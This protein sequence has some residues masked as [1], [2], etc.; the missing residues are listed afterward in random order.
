MDSIPLEQQ[1]EDKS[2]I[3]VL[4]EVVGFDSNRH[5]HQM[6]TALYGHQFE[7]HGELPKD[8]TV[9]VLVDVRVYRSEAK[10]LVKSESASKC[11]P[12]THISMNHLADVV[13]LCAGM[14]CLGFGLQAAGFR[15]VAKV[16]WNQNMLR[17]AS[18]IDSTPT[19]C[20][21]ICQPNAIGSLCATSPNAGCLAAGIA[22]QPYSRL[23]DQQAQRDSRA[24]TL[25][26]VLR[27]AFL[28][29]YAI[30]VIECVPEAM[31]CKWVQ[32]T[33]KHYCQLT[34]FS[35][36]QDLLHLHHVWPTRRSRWWCVLS[37]PC[38]GKIP[39]GPL[40][41][42]DPIPMVS[43]L[44]D[45]FLQCTEEDLR[46][47][48]LDLY[49]L[50]KFAHFGV[51]TNMIP[52]K[53]QMK[54]SL[55]SCGNQ[56]DAC[57]C[58][59]RKY[60]FSEARLSQG[61]LHGLL[62]PL[63]GHSQCGINIYQNMRHVHPD[64]LA[65][66][67]GMFPGLSWNE[68][69]RLTL[70]ALGQLASPLQSCWVGAHIMLHLQGRFGE[71][72]GVTPRECLFGLMRDLLMKR[73][74]VFGIQHGPDAKAFAKMV[75]NRVFHFSLEPENPP[76]QTTS[77][78]G[79]IGEESLMS[80]LGHIK[81]ETKVLTLSETS[82][83]FPAVPAECF[84]AS[85]H[86]HDSVKTTSND[87][88]GFPFSVASVPL[89]D[90]QSET[91]LNTAG[92]H[93]FDL[94][95][96]VCP[97]E[98]LSG[99]QDFA[100]VM[101]PDSV[102]TARSLPHDPCL[103]SPCSEPD[104]PCLDK[105]FHIATQ[106]A[107]VPTCP[108][109]TE[110]S[111]E[112]LLDE[113]L[114]SHFL[115]VDKTVENPQAISPAGH[116]AP[117]MSATPGHQNAVLE[118]GTEK[119]ND[120]AIPDSAAL[121]IP[122]GIATD[123]LSCIPKELTPP[124][125]PLA[126]LT[127]PGMTATPGNQNAGSFADGNQAGDTLPLKLDDSGLAMPPGL[128]TMCCTDDAA[129]KLA[130]LD[131]GIS[132]LPACPDLAANIESMAHTNAGQPAPGMAATPGQ[133]DA[134]RAC[135][136]PE[137]P[138]E[139]PQPRV[140]MPPA[141]GGVVGFETGY[142]RTLAGASTG[143]IEHCAKTMQS[144][145]KIAKTSVED[146]PSLAEAHVEVAD[147][148]E[149]A[150]STSIQVWV[151]TH[152]TDSPVLVTCH[153]G[154]TAGMITQAEAN[155]GNMH[156]PI[157]PR[158]WVG[159]HVPLHE[160]LR[161]KQ[162]VI[163]HAKIPKDLKCPIAGGCQTPQIPFPCHRL[164]ALWKQ[165][166]WVA[167]DEME[168]YLASA[169]NV[170]Q[171]N[172]LPPQTFLNDTAVRMEAAAWL[173]QPIDW[174]TGD[175]PWITAAIVAGHWVP[176]IFQKSDG[177]ISLTTT[178][179][180]SPFIEAAQQVTTHLGLTLKAAQKMLPQAFH[181]DCGFQSFAWIMAIL[182]G[183]DVEPFDPVRAEKWRY[184]FAEH[185]LSVKRHD[186]VIDRLEL[187]GTKS[188]VALQRQLMD[189]L[190]NHG[191]WTERLTDKSNQLMEGV[192][193]HILKNVFL[194]KR[195]WADLKQ[196]ANNAQ[197]MIKLVQPDELNAQIAA[198][199]NQR[200]TYGQKSGQYTKKQS[201]TSDMPN[202]RAADLQVPHG[203]FK[204]Q[205]GQVLGPLSINDVGSSCQGVVLVDQS[206][207]EP[208][209]RLQTPVTPHG[210]A[211]IVLAT[212]SNALSHTQDPIRFPALCLATQ[213]PLIVSGYLYQLGTQ[214]TL[215][216][217]PTVKLAVEEHDTR[218]IR[219]LVF[220]DQAD[221]L[222]QEIQKQPVKVIFNQEPLLASRGNGDQPIVIDVWDRQWLSKRFEK[223]K[224]TVAE[225]FVFSFRMLAPHADDLIAKSG[226]HGIYY[227]PRTQCGR[228]PC[229]D[230]HV[231]WLTKMSYQ[232]AQFAQQTSPF[233]TTLTR[234]GDRFG[235]RSDNL[236]AQAIHDKHRPDT[237]LLLGQKKSL[238]TMGPMPFAA[239]KD[240]ITK[241]LK[242]WG[243]DARALQPRGRA[244]DS[245]GITWCIQA[246]E[247]PTHWVYTLQHGDVLISRIR[248]RSPVKVVPVN[249]VA[250]KKTIEH[251]QQGED[252][253]LKRDP[254]NGS[255]ASPV[256]KP[257]AASNPTQAQLAQLEASVE[258]RVLAAIQAKHQDAD[259]SM[260]NDNIESRVSQLEKQIQQV[261]SHQVGM[262]TKI[263]QMQNQ[264]EVQGQQF[265]ASLDMK[266]AAQMDKIEALFSKRVRHE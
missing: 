73:D 258:K 187:G 37:H 110:R 17:L 204:Q 114:E 211:V 18:N 35:M 165:Q 147:P 107:R 5:V 58:G 109:G 194:S 19:V 38:I 161:N 54:T 174:V 229:P 32:D 224:P 29:R 82:D 148:D 145:A 26:A 105:S 96:Q 208:L 219:C 262:D 69:P 34:G 84:R 3:T 85:E 254:W 79:V 201:P 118:T 249:I 20:L 180:G 60:P 123:M 21:D 222:W 86:S 195:P 167:K 68:K 192:P 52:W 62:I 108:A 153:E 92:D 56:L 128:K 137:E 216:L 186:V 39:W 80:S 8:S 248:D 13:E 239:T 115:G 198:R 140:F 76:N 188:D 49:E 203:V 9:V 209:L 33:L 87:T 67:N 228:F 189:L 15:T 83:N 53:G 152:D 247:D 223:L 133:H 266:L 65:L 240:S 70:C 14:G 166:G 253:W 116:S 136:S 111:I 143:D 41:Q 71:T 1:F 102:V 61:G 181:G 213:E 63:E 259:V 230:H 173:H 178:P 215:R 104:T 43:N 197:P 241:L 169:K 25:P 50:G 257:A 42:V 131:H 72:T 261:H 176:L 101:A 225:I 98:G 237:P 260:A 130:K 89:K 90:E 113:A 16:D 30:V 146:Q 156:Q 175:R 199:A 7:F 218:T 78:H 28:G 159:S 77:K 154:S 252:P 124:H 57:P 93:A 141:N 193:H 117:G 221:K 97:V 182:G 183:H 100:P 231:T 227:E 46:H 47:L 177:A 135:D 10:F 122:H 75:D 127:T 64:E 150:F 196:A 217:E 162:V 191:V 242:T 170:C 205:D 220:Q 81:D 206:D 40:P 185:L 74:Q 207:S 59:C 55:H 12:R 142:K 2:L 243:W 256:T 255:A 232:D 112:Q 126:G 103:T 236:N 212:K 6:K 139:V 200:R 23:G 168:Y 129:T 95:H 94:H 172:I 214:Q 250:S 44:L 263:N 158:S 234:H 163:L 235:L 226:Q 66:L 151:G 155:I 157:A 31:S 119:P 149:Q 202:M 91:L 27:L 106:H 264:L 265:N 190:A 244:A 245:S 184:L 51:D 171:V 238:Y 45:R 233:T 251:L 121:L 132:E 36:T 179:E 210:L 24:L 144:P 4:A 120:Q 246:V 22:C 164:I 99:E 160:P 134:A 138:T 125:P 11:F 48:A 88:S